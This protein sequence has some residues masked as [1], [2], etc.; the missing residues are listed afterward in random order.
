MAFCRYYGGSNYS[1][2]GCLNA[3]GINKLA[4]PHNWEYIPIMKEK[5]SYSQKVLADN[6]LRLL[7]PLIR[8]LLRNGIGFAHFSE[9]VKFAY[10]DVAEKDFPLAGRAQSTSRIAT[11]TGL[12]RKEVARLR[13][14]LQEDELIFKPAKANRA[15]RVINAWLREKTYLNK[16]GQP[17]ALALN[18]PAPSFDSLAHLASGD[19]HS[20]AILDELLRIKAVEWRSDNKLILKTAGYISTD[21]DD[22]QLNIFGQCT[23]DLLSSLDHNLTSGNAHKKL[24]R[25][26]AYN[27]LNNEQI[28]AFQRYSQQKSEQLLLELNTW[29]AERNTP[30][31]EQ[32]DTTH[33]YRTGIGIYY[34]DNIKHDS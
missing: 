31:S 19:I 27:G 9:W 8:L 14:A 33:Y 2:I 28:L 12:H 13:A 6:I 20:T 16:K 11:L 1:V 25:S 30:E 32:S 18:G 29:L 10:V 22:E 15:E 4:K 3:L 21:H 26:V 17:A 7:R 24:Q 34:F 5:Q 23:E